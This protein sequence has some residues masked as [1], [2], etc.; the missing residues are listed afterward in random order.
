MQSS[1]QTRV[2]ESI[3][4]QR[5]LRAGD[6]AGVA[7]SGGADSVALLRLL[8]DLRDAL[9]IRLLVLHFNHQLR[10]SDA[11]EDQQFVEKLAAT[12][13]L[14]F[15]IGSQD[16]RAAASRESWNLEDAARRLRYQ[17]F[18]QVIAD[19][20]ATRV[21][22]A[23]TAD[24]QAETVLSH[25]LRGTG[26][27]GL[28]GI[29]PVMPLGSGAIIRPL[30]E[31]RRSELRQLLAVLG[32]PWREDVS[33]EDTTRLRARIRHRL[34]PFLE[35]DFEP[36]AVTQLCRLASLAADEEA[37]WEAWVADALRSKT[38][39]EASGAIAIRAADLLQP[40]G[41]DPPVAPPSAE[42]TQGL[43]AASAAPSRRLI[44][45]IYQ[46][47]R[48]DRTGLTARHTDQVLRLA[49]QSA[50]QAHSEGSSAG[51]ASGAETHL[52]GVVVA[53]DF[54]TLRFSLALAEN[55]AGAISA[56]A[57]GK[58][59]RFEYPIRL[60]GAE[61]AEVAVPEIGR[62]LRLKLIDWPQAS[63]ETGVGLGALDRDRLRSPLVVR[64]WLP[65]DSFRP[66]GRRHI[67]KLKRLLLER[68]VSLRDRAGWPVLTSAGA[69]VWARGFPVAAE[70]AAALGTEVGVLIE[71]ESL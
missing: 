58:A 56:A 37:F 57:R 52:P 20:R 16:V 32:Q 2:L 61:S 30:L 41:F 43:A 23:H 9:G 59:A 8:L 34:L 51:R 38:Q 47:L 6:T 49:R 13:H 40:I 12:H 4:R 65:G 3:S 24:D 19:R 69:I 63:R 7:V 21:A 46:E 5:M 70:F 42:F 15:V 26:L 64:S 25:L 62:R 14:E 28:A 66:S 36:Q 53:R 67:R 27:T 22:V 17:F 31:V 10:G 18:D 48:G 35:K 50:S 45:R 11:A 29:H 55:A 33:N 54:E 60:E 68:R 1:I 44:R 71:E 39:R